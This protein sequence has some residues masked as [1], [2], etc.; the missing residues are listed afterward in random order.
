MTN[1]NLFLLKIDAQKKR[2]ENIIAHQANLTHL[3]E[4]HA[5]LPGG[6]LCLVLCPLILLCGVVFQK[7]IN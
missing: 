5:V 4:Y 6:W 1:L 2:K 7:S 3:Q